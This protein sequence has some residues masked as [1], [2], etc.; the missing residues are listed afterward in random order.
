MGLWSYNAEAAGLCR[1][2]DRAMLGEG[3][4]GCVTARSL[5]L[6]E[7]EGLGGKTVAR[8]LGGGAGE[9]KRYGGAE[10][11]PC[12]PGSGS[13]SVTGFFLLASFG[14]WWTSR[15]PN[16]SEAGEIHFWITEGT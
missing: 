1:E 12:G 2:T 5:G 3:A 10:C 4:R 11:R 15:G 9:G 7:M 13:L 6:Q 8:G 16:F 14:H